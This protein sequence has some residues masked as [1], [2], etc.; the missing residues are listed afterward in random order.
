M[1]RVPNTCQ[2]CLILKHVRLSPP[3]SQLVISDVW[4]LG[5]ACTRDGLSYSDGEVLSEFAS[6]THLDYATSLFDGR[7]TRFLQE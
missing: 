3:R 1:Q 5:A 4:T 2:H 7:L 6:I